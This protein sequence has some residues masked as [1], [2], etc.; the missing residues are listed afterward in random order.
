MASA[1]KTLAEMKKAGVREYLAKQGK[2][3]T[4][5]TVE[6][7]KKAAAFATAKWKQAATQPNIPQIGTGIAGTAV[8]VTAGTLIHSGLDR[9]TS[10]WVKAD[11]AAPG[12]AVSTTARKIVV[13]FAVPVLGT[14][15][16]VGS[17]MLFK[18][19]G[20]GAAF[21]MGLGIGALIGS[22]LRSINTPLAITA[23]AA[24]N[25]EI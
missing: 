13:H 5:A 17:A 16:A 21:G 23:A 24:P 25:G 1:E 6:G 15:I 18:K 19:H 22:L 3:A 9:A 4:A 8:G 20:V 12:Q 7:A 2:A 14:A 10:G 11:E